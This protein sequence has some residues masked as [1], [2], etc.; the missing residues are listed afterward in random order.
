MDEARAAIETRWK[1]VQSELSAARRNARFG[2]ARASIWSSHLAEPCLGRN[3]NSGRPP[4]LP[5][6]RLPI[7]AKNKKQLDL[8]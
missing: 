7:T 6:G 3:R 4:P 8:I 2:V 5:R 1:T